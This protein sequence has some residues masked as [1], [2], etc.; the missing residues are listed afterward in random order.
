ML[1]YILA[2]TE[3]VAV[4]AIIADHFSDD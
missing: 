4:V 1:P 2:I 3:L